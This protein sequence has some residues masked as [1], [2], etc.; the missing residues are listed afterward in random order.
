[1]PFVDVLTTMLDDTLPL[2]PP[3]WPEWGN[4]IENS[5][6]FATIL[7][8]S[9]VDRVEAKHYPPI[10]ALAGLTDSRVTYWEAAKWVARLGP[11]RPMPI[12]CSCASTWTPAMAAPRAVSTG[13][14]SRAGTG[15]RRDDD[16]ANGA[17]SPRLK[18]SRRPAPAKRRTAASASKRCGE[19]PPSCWKKGASF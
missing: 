17:H 19:E 14:R 6:A 15:L 5:A 18:P 12:R 4:P 8:Y 9:P 2:T 3:E 13:S 7:A 16:G 11:S 10:L 1:V